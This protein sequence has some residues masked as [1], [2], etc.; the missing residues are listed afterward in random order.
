VQDRRLFFLLNSAQQALRQRV[1]RECLARVGLTSAQM[2][3][4]YYVAKH[5]GCVLKEL[6][7]GLRLKSAAVTGLLTRTE[8]T[9]CVRRE[10]SRAD[11]RATKLH[12]T[13]KGQRKLLE[14]RRLNESFNEQLRSGF[15]A[16]EIELVLRFLRHVHELA[17]GELGQ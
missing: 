15:S 5:D 12:L 2:G 1:D 14:I 4:L 13:A 6:A 11:A 8:A 17:A 9:G 16:S 10:V 7:S 3:L